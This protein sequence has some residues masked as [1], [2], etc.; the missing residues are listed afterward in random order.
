MKNKKKKV[1]EVEKVQDPVKEVTELFFRMFF[2][3]F[4][5][6]IAVFMCWYGYFV[7]NHTF[8]DVKGASMMPTLNNSIP[9]SQMESANNMHFDSVHIK[10]ETPN[11]FDVVIIK[12]PTD[13]D[14]IIKR[15]VAQE[16]DYVTIAK[17][18]DENGNASF[19]LFRIAAG[20]QLNDFSDEEAMLSE[21]AENGYTILEPDTLWVH[22][23]TLASEFIEVEIKVDGQSFKHQYEYNFYWTFLNF[24]SEDDRPYNYFVSDDG[25]LYVQVP[26]G[27]FFFMGDNRAHSTDAREDGFCNTEYILGKVDYVIE[28]NNFFVRIFSL[29]K[30]FFGKI[31][32]FFAR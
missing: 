21:N 23:K 25:L 7:L 4:L 24:Y 5:V 15:V 27:Q 16:G 9:Y 29:L 17:V 31:E 20:S 26:K 10:V 18:I 12:R 14:S 1:E 8:Y 22:K 3:L 11:L 2:Y 28:D 6:F 32:K 19:K 30:I 13:K